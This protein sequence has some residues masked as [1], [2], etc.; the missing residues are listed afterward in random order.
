MHL[1]PGI[2]ITL[3]YI[4]L[5]PFF[6]QRGFPP[7]F[8]LCL[9]VLVALIPVK[10]GFLLYIGKKTNGRLSLKNVVLYRE[11]VP[12]WQYVVYGLFILA[13]SA[14]TFAFLS[15]SVGGFITDFFSHGLQHGM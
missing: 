13:W 15:K 8:A 3:F 14:L 11:H 5:A 6:V 12:L 9:T 2:I 10:L 4:V 7:V 1:F